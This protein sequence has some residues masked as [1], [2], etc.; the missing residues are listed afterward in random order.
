MSPASCAMN[1]HGGASDSGDKFT[2][3]DRDAHLEEP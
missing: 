2:P 1:A 3:L